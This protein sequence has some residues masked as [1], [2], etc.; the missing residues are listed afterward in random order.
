MYKESQ[1]AFSMTSIILDYQVVQCSRI[2]LQVMQG[3]RFNPCVGEI[4]WSRKW[5]PSPVFLPG[6]F[7]EQRGLEGCLSWDLKELDETE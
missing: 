6:K 4:P 7:H 2:C 5:Q 1:I 3:C